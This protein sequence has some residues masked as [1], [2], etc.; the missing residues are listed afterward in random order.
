MKKIDIKEFGINSDLD[1]INFVNKLKKLTKS[2]YYFTDGEERFFV[3]EFEEDI[4]TLQSIVNAKIA[5]L[6]EKILELEKQIKELQVE[7]S[8]KIEVPLPEAKP[9]PIEVPAIT[10][11]PLPDLPKEE[12]PK[13]G[14]KSRLEE[15]Q[16]TTQTI[17]PTIPM[18]TVTF[19]CP[20]CNNVFSENVPKGKKIVEV[21]CPQC[22]FTV[23]KKKGFWTKKR[24]IAVAGLAVLA[25]IIWLFLP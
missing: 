20:S 17:S 18:Q 12:P 15:P 4:P 6:D 16:E 2:V 23:Y 25:F 19:K 11:P 22:G 5:I 14:F 7:I 3:G 13:L 9:Q 10:F 1:A 21:H 8:R 24:K